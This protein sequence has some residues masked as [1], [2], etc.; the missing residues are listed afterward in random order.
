M[1]NKLWRKT[2]EVIKTNV[3]DR[4]KS[5]A[6]KELQEEF[7]KKAKEKI[8]SKMRDLENAKKLRRRWRCRRCRWF[9]HPIVGE[10]TGP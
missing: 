3:I 8:K 4:L 9:L 5:D 6:A 1:F 7:E 10:C 2:V